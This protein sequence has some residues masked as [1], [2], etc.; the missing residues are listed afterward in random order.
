M[1]RAAN[2]PIINTHAAL[3]AWMRVTA[4]NVARTTIVTESRRHRRQNANSMHELREL[5]E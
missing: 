1:R 2:P 4:L 3:I 5:R